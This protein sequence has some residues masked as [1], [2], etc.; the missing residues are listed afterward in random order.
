M[1]STVT[2]IDICNRAL[3][4]V[5]A[6]IINS[7]DDGSGQANACK[8][9]YPDTKLQLLSQFPWRFATTSYALNYLDVSTTD[10]WT[11]RWQLPDDYVRAIRLTANT[12]QVTAYEIFGNEIHNNYDNSS[13]LNLEYIRDVG[14]TYFPPYFRAALEDTLASQLGACLTSKANMA[15]FWEKKA[16]RSLSVARF[17]DS[18]IDQP[19]T[20]LVDDYVKARS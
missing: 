16:M 19:D 6:D 3:M 18:S 11:Y 9:L 17:A 20:I 14:E 12:V 2:S 5:S 15:D 10:K 7:F 13:T 8:L 1:A 4:K